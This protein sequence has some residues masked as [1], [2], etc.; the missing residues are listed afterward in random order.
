MQGTEWVPIRYFAAKAGMKAEDLATFIAA[1]R[2]TPGRKAL[3]NQRIATADK[4][5][6]RVS[7]PAA[8]LQ[9][10]LLDGE[11]TI[12]TSADEARSVA[13]AVT[14]LPRPL[15]LDAAKLRILL[16]R[17]LDLTGDNSTQTGRSEVRKAIARLDELL[18]PW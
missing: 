8:Q 10:Q 16:L 13:L 5:Y 11:D 18:S 12:P 6:V 4:A 14:G 9:R 17:C 15:T 7:G 2:G 1:A 3:L